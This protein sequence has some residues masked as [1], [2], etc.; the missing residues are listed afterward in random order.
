M[1]ATPQRVVE[2]WIPRSRILELRIGCLTSKCIEAADRLRVQSTGEIGR[3]RKTGDA[4]QRL[5]ARA[6]EE[7]RVFPGQDVGEADARFENRRGIDG[8]GIPRGRL[9]LERVD[10]SV[11]RSA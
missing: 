3:R 9:L 10:K 2:L 8:P 5:K 4:I 7:G 11:A 1:P 6:A